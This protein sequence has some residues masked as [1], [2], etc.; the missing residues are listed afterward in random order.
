MLVTMI[1]MRIMIIVSIDFTISRV[2]MVIFFFIV[3]VSIITILV[4]FT[5]SPTHAIMGVFLS[6]VVVMTS[7][8]I[9]WL[10]LVCSRSEFWCKSH[11]RGISIINRISL[12]TSMVRK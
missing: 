6:I 1:I 12:A 2:M 11:L 8:M 10:R 3:V 5:T 4:V 7:W 9:L